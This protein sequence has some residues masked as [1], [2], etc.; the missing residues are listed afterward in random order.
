MIAAGG[1]S[2]DGISVCGSS[3]GGLSRR[4]SAGNTA[5]V[6]TKRLG[7]PE[8][9]LQPGAVD[10]SAAVIIH[11]LTRNSKQDTLAGAIADLVNEYCM[12][13]R[14]ATPAMT[15][16]LKHRRTTGG[17]EAQKPAIRRIK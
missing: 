7:A 14:E 12:A 15:M 16:P 9:V 8:M 3:A 1:L 10:N 13:H 17:D 5:L 6:D 11:A 4:L 2:S